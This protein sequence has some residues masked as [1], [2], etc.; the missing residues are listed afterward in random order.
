MSGYYLR[1]HSF[2]IQQKSSH[3]REEGVRNAAS[4]TIP[5]T[6][7]YPEAPSPMFR[8]AHSDVRGR[9]PLPVR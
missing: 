6:F 9:T 1:A 3:W 2:T 5:R 8:T 4:S 7:L